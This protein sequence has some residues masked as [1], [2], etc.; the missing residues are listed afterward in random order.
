MVSAETLAVAMR[1]GHTEA[2]SGSRW[3]SRAA[4]VGDANGEH[5]FVDQRRRVSI[6]VGTR[7]PPGG[8]TMTTRSPPPPPE[9]ED[10]DE[11]EGPAP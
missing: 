5:R 4:R 11:E 9:E 6:R 7:M 8:S 2:R 1:T 10:E 3:C